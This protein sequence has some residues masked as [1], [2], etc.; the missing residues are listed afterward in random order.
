[1]T[2]KERISADMKAAMKSGDSGK[3]T[4][5]RGLLSV[6]NNK[7]IE[8]RA[9]TGTEEPMSDEEVTNALLTEA[10]KRKESMEVFKTAGR[11][12]LADN[13]AKELVVIQEYL[14]KQMSPEETQAAVE[15][16]LAKTGAKE[17][18]PAMKAV[19]AELRGKVDSALATDI[20][21]KKLGA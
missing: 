14:P 21:K 9:K 11:A 19:M 17:F 3:L 20:V 12:D 15:A 10:K 7:A 13:E 6:I 8:K 16:I 1:M 5:L 18:G 4:T 2:L